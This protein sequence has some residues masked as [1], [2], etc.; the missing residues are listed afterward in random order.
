MTITGAGAGKSFILILT[1]DSPTA[2][3]MTWPVNVV[4]PGGTQPSLSG[5]GKRDIF[6]FFYDPT[7]PSWLATTIGQNYT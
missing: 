5:A 4:W 3:T 6:S 2:R 7:T 1:Q